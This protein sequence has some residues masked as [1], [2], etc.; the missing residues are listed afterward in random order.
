[1]NNVR[2]PKSIIGIVLD[3]VVQTALNSPSVRNHAMDVAL[4]IC[5]DGKR[6]HR[7]RSWQFRGSWIRCGIRAE[8]SDALDDFAQS[9]LE[10]PAYLRL[11]LQL[12]NFAFNVDA[13]LRDFPVRD[14]SMPVATAFE[15]N[16]RRKS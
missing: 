2:L 13:H 4:P 9:A 1:M 15:Q 11:A 12:Q 3:E 16:R 7:W 6:L 8:L 10:P 5:L 14:E